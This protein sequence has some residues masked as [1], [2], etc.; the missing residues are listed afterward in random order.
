MNPFIAPPT[1]LGAMAFRAEND[2]YLRRGVHLRIFAGMGAA[3]PVTPFIVC[4]V[5][6][7]PSP[8]HEGAHVMLASHP[9]LRNLS[10][11]VMPIGDPPVRLSFEP[12]DGDIGSISMLD[13]S[14]ARTI[15]TRSSRPWTF[16]LPDW[17]WV[18]VRGDA[19]RL[20]ATA[21]R[22]PDDALVHGELGQRV[23][24][25]LAL[26]GEPGRQYA[27]Y[28]GWEKDSEKER[29]VGEGWLRVWGPRETHVFGRWRLGNDGAFEPLAAPVVNPA[30]AA[31]NQ[32]QEEVARVRK[33]L[34]YAPPD[35][36]R[37][38]RTMLKTRQLPPWEQ[39]ASINSGGKES[40]QY[41]PLQM[42]Q[43]G[44][45]D[46]GLARHFGYATTWPEDELQLED[47]DLL[48]VY[49]IIVFDPKR[50][51][52]A[53][54]GTLRQTVERLREAQ[55]SS[56]LEKKILQAIADDGMENDPAN[57]LAQIKE[58][59]AQ[60]GLM[61]APFV[62]YTAAVK[63]YDPPA[64]P[65][66]QVVRR[67]WAAPEGNTPSD[68]YSAVFAFRNLPMCTLALLERQSGNEFSPR[69]GSNQDDAADAHVNWLKPSVFGREIESESRR[70][71][72]SLSG[73][74]VRAALL[75]DVGIPAE[76]S[77]NYRARAS[78]VFGRFGPPGVFEAEAPER[79]QP[80]VPRLNCQY[81]KAD[82]APT[83]EGKASPGTLE[84][85]ARFDYDID[86]MP[87]AHEVAVPGVA[88]SPRGALQIET[89]ELSLSGTLEEFGQ[90]GVQTPLPALPPVQ[91][92]RN[93]TSAQLAI[94]G[95]PPMG[96]A[97]L[98][99]TGVYIDTAGTRSQESTTEMTV[100]DVR[101]PR[102]LNTGVGL[103]WTT[104]P[105]AA[106]EVT[107]DLV[108]NAPAGSEH[109][110]YLGDERTL[111][112]LPDDA[113]RGERGV[114][115]CK[116]ARN[117]EKTKYQR[118]TP[119]ALKASP[120]NQVA[121]P[122]RLPRSLESVQVLRVVPLGPDGAE[123]DFDD[124]TTVPVAVP[125]S[126]RESP[127]L[128]V[129]E[130]DPATG[131]AKLKVIVDGLNLEELKREQPGLFDPEKEGKELPR[132]RLRCSSGKVSHPI[133]AQVQRGAQGDD[134]A[135]PLELKSE[136][137]AGETR[138]WFE[139]SVE[140]KP[141]L[142]YVNYVYWAEVRLPPER[143]VPAHVIQV[144]S[145]VKA[146][147]AESAEPSER[148]WGELSGALV[149]MHT[150]PAQ[151]LAAEDAGLE[152][153][154]DGAPRAKIKLTLTDLPKLSAKAVDVFRLAAWYRWGDRALAPVLDGNGVS[155]DGKWPDVWALPDL[156]VEQAPSP[157]LSLNV[158]VG[159]LDP[160]GRMG[161]ITVLSV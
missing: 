26:P 157:G 70:K 19:K 107:L 22:P 9:G 98:K 131:A 111:M 103:L 121:Y 140:G 83:G 158:H 152:V 89:L 27:W 11:S 146:V 63:P 64:V 133:Y 1:L 52:E 24:R 161:P 100:T 112:Q 134:G 87:A 40:A 123:P 99:L 42:L 15:A 14:G 115:L 91:L 46:Y 67:Q 23:C 109:L 28:V 135:M 113:P 160:T 155:L 96:R 39:T 50:I 92:T 139:A 18:N 59:A 73:A 141:L 13:G 88:Q 138:Y 57:E 37:D 60:L 137:V 114:A 104:R 66:A 108:W 4:K 49:A 142:P 147:H 38:V 32:A 48:A 116:A 71:E 7:R 105:S 78:D 90:P 58:A 75:S 3:F 143:C 43:L 16:S 151:Q 41:S 110:L 81:K 20:A 29:R 144:P 74:Q 6:G 61:V 149:L 80:T 34:S 33:L 150:P 2:E 55:L 21:L 8:P 127:P 122:L 84:I 124:C 126:R 45:G 93:N 82:P 136:Q 68:K 153:L 30:P 130:V 65:R 128:L 12:I 47:D 17:R 56:E 53:D 86:N 119:T 101:A 10:G 77:T 31:G 148:L 69:S 156:F 85:S 62:T 79:P 145:G 36:S 25:G 54:P 154:D 106:P 97:R 35:L 95:L 72:L 76:G 125:S 118:I 129:G 159:L 44:M 94:P 5:K 51:P 120:Q 117:H 132:F 102:P